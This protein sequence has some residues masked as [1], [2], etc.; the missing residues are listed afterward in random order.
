[1]PR[2]QSHKIRSVTT[3]NYSSTPPL[4]F[5]RCFRAN[6]ASLKPP[7]KTHPGEKERKKELK[8]KEE[9]MRVDEVKNFIKNSRG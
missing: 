7:T 3:F 2:G 4:P 8:E 6:D 5:T 1:M 9:K